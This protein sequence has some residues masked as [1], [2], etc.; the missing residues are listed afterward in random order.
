MPTRRAKA[1]RPKVAVIAPS[2]FP[3][4]R[5]GEHYGFELCL[6]H[7]ADGLAEH[8][9]TTLIAPRGS[10]CRKTAVMETIDPP[11]QWGDEEERAFRIYAPRLEEFDVVIDN[12]HL[13]YAYQLASTLFI[14]PLPGVQTRLPQSRNYP[15][16]VSLSEWHRKDTK[17]RFGVDSRI[18]HYGLDPD[19]YPLQTKR[20]KRVV[21]FGAILPHKGVLEAVEAWPKNPKNELVV[22]GSDSF[23]APK[24]Y[25]TKVK[26][27]CAR[28]GVPYLG[29]VDR[30]TKMELLGNSQAVLTTFLRG[31]AYSV[32]AIEAMLMG[33]PVLATDW[34]DGVPNAYTFESLPLLMKRAAAF[35]Q[36]G[37]ANAEKMRV[38]CERR[39]GF[40]RMIRLYRE[41][42]EDVRQG[43]F[44]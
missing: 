29:T 1:N 30:K 28:K 27:T 15:C 6:A 3:A 17:L 16:L 36:G 39:W 4:Q 2:V 38:F 8:Y 35:D 20:K 9:E 14:G 5:S 41:A 23:G 25:V 24:D 43:V 44:W 12:S 19:D 21:V 11:D 13:K 32:L 40:A 10:K 31:E 34:N 42:I 18:I 26:E 33:T 7:L 37:K 22:A